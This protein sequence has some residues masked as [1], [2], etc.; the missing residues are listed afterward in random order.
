[1]HFRKLCFP[2]IEVA[3]VHPIHCISHSFFWRSSFGFGRLQNAS[4]TRPR[5]IILIFLLFFIRSILRGKQSTKM[6]SSHRLHL[7]VH[8]V[9]KSSQGCRGWKNG[10]RYD[11][12]KKA[13][14]EFSFVGQHAYAVCFFRLFCIVPFFFSRSPSSK[15]SAL[16][17]RSTFLTIQLWTGWFWANFS[18]NHPD[19]GWLAH[20]RHYNLFWLLKIR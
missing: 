6:K 19:S 12:A 1:M 18:A 13:A 11:R 14:S 15:C 17:F 5:A 16:L 20:I 4:P 10:N 7:D 8:K 9:A 3:A 2:T